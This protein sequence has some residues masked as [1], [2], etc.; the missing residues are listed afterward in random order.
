MEHIARLALRGLGAVC[1]PADVVEAVDQPL[2]Q[3]EPERQDLV[4]PWGSHEGRQR[5][6]LDAELDDEGGYAARHAT[7][8]R[9]SAQVREAL[10]ALGVGVFLEDGEGAYSSI[11]TSFHQP[12]G[13]SY[14]ALHDGLKERGFVIYAG[15]G[16]YLGKMF[17]IA[18]LGALD[19]GDLAEL[20]AALRALISLSA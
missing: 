8:A 20:V 2:A 13:V 10:R 6:A 4:V 19:E 12:P 16:P 5:L 1:E 3:Q 9:R 7:Y 14:A 11:L 17:R 18:V 15:Q